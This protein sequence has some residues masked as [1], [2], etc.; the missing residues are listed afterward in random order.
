MRK[1]AEDFHATGKPLHVLVDN[2]G[3]GNFNDNEKA[4]TEDGFELHMGTNH[5]G[6]S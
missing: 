5:L 2:A 4:K 3:F 6:E 1:F